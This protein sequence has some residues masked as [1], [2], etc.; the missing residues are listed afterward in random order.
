MAWIVVTRLM[1]GS[2]L[3]TTAA[4]SHALAGRLRTGNSAA[5]SGCYRIEG[6]V[7]A[8]GSNVAITDRR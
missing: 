4:S 2:W 7:Q 8:V 1:R 5:L 6:T 3:R